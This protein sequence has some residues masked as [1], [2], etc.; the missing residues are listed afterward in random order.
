MNLCIKSDFLIFLL[1]GTKIIGITLF[2]KDRG[3]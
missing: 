2:F 3:S 1:Q